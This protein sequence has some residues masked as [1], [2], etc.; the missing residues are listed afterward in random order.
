MK[1]IISFLGCSDHVAGLNEEASSKI[2]L[3]AQTVSNIKWLQE[4]WSDIQ[5]GCPA[6]RCWQLTYGHRNAASICSSS[7]PHIAHHKVYKK[8][9]ILHLKWCRWWN[10]WSCGTELVELLVMESPSWMW[11]AQTISHLL[12]SHLKVLCGVEG[13]GLERGGISALTR[14]SLRLQGLRYAMIARVSG[15]ARCRR[16]EVWRMWWLSLMITDGR[17]FGI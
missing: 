12:A 15:T 8:S 11:L 5:Q 7:L 1:L 16:S 17:E 3:L 10:P 13:A 4:G 14:K 2:S 6:S 9:D